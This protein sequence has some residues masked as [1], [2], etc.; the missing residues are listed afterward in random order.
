V[1]GVTT[2]K[3]RGGGGVECEKGRRGR[4]RPAKQGGAEGGYEGQG[5]EGYTGN[6]PDRKG[7]RNGSSA[8]TGRGK[9]V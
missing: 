2:G 3:R 5:G 8:G 1:G 6:R 4:G 9:I 7:D